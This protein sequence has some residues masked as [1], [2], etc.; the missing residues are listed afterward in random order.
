MIQF[1]THPNPHWLHGIDSFAVVHWMRLL[2]HDPASISTDPDTV[3]EKMRLPHL[4]ILLL[5]YAGMA[6]AGGATLTSEFGLPLH[7]TF[8]PEQYQ[9]ES[10]TFDVDVSSDNLVYVANSTGLL[11]FDGEQWRTIRGTEGRIVIAVD[12]DSKDRI[13][14]GMVRDLGVVVPDSSGQLAFHSLLPQMPEELEVSAGVWRV[15]ATPIGIFYQIPHFLVRW[16][17]D[18]SDPLKG[19]ATIWSANGRPF[20]MTS[21]VNEALYVRRQRTPVEKLDGDSLVIVPE[22]ASVGLQ[23]FVHAAPVDSSHLILTAF[24]GSIHLAG[25]EGVTLMPGEVNDLAEGAVAFGVTPLT[26]DRFAYSSNTGITIFNK[27]G[28]VLETI[29]RLGTLS[30]RNIMR[31]ATVDCT[32]GAWFPLDYGLVRVEFDR[33][34][35]YFD[36]QSGLDGTIFSIMRFEGH[37]YVATSNG[38]YRLEE[39]VRP[40]ALATFHKMEGIDFSVLL[41]RAWGNRLYLATVRGLHYLESGIIHSI[42]SFNGNS[43]GMAIS[44]DHRYLY[45][46]T[47]LQGIRLFRIDTDPVVDLGHIGTSFDKF[48]RSIFDAEGRFW[49]VNS[50]PVGDRLLRSE[51]DSEQPGKLDL[52]LFDESHGLHGDVIGAPFEWEDSLRVITRDGLFCYDRETDRFHA[53][54]REEFSLFS[55]AYILDLP[56]IDED[57]WLYINTGPYRT[58]RI[59]LKERGGVAPGN[60]LARSRIQR[61]LAIYPDPVTG[62][63]ICGG[64]DGRLLVIQPTDL[65]PPPSILLREVRIQDHSVL[66]LNS[67]N[68]ES[69]A[70]TLQGPV[71]S[72]R[73]VYALTSFEAPESNLYQFRLLGRGTEWSEWSRETYRDFNDLLEGVYHFE[74]RG[75]DYS[76]QVSEPA[77]FTLK[78]LPPWYRTAIFRAAIIL[79]S[80][81]VIFLIIWLRTKQLRRQQRTL[82]ALIAQRT[83]EL[84][85][86]QEAE[87]REMEARKAAEYETQRLKTVANL[88]TTIAHELNNPLAVIQGRIEVTELNHEVSDEIKK[89]HESI[90]QQV[91][92]M[93]SLV[94]K[95]CKI[96]SIRLVDYAGGVKMLD[97]KSSIEDTSGG[98]KVNP[99]KE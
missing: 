24:T 45:L 74:V 98:S 13:W 16:I 10:Q 89:A 15:R 48:D 95:L 71:S 41:M 68:R 83:E 8:T 57:G 78:V 40:G 26:G 2:T 91:D 25:P 43:V 93:S 17:P 63:V 67:Y 7:R 59:N 69:F 28:E 49:V 46:S 44:P 52:E 66:H 62:L 54:F 51:Y 50:L 79:L 60:I 5:L 81:G 42:E 99:T 21:Y 86:A 9:G 85:A 33:P 82:E 22:W 56:A 39:Q 72:V 73:F 90:Q 92:R 55:D 58:V 80:L 12:V 61:V 1:F 77:V 97:L 18:P 3:S 38:L 32:G 65:E 4:I 76:G 11:E 70:S 96:E 19:E 34:Q 37:L 87:I 36:S 27:S 88:A 30:V 84:Q 6:C 53:H 31:E 14:V 64:D 75:M 23:T 20:T 47:E 94:A 29:D 35:R